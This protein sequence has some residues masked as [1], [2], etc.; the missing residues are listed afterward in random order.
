MWN[1][2]ELPAPLQ[3]RADH[4]RPLLVEALRRDE[5]PELDSLLAAD[6]TLPRALDYLLAT[7]EFV[8]KTCCA[9]PRLLADLLASGEL[10]APQTQAQLEQ[11]REI[12]LASPDVGELDK[13]LR[14][15]RNQAMVRL[16]W[17]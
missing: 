5:L 17:R 8:A 14:Q 7:S 4:Y 15:W 11:L 13:R 16:I 3:A 2:S 9:R 6:E 1:T 12:L 10:F